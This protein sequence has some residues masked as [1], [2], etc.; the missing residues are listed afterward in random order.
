MNKND[1]LDELYG[2]NVDID[3]Y[4]SYSRVADFSKNGPKAL[5][6]RQKLEGDGI[7]IGSLTDD[8]L[9]NQ[10]NFN[11]IYFVFNGEKPTATLGKLVNIIQL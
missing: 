3:I 5:I 7:K 9:F 2:S 1:E 4:L 10:K 6:I 11:D 8:W